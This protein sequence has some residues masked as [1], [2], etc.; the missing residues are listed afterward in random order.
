[1]SDKKDMLDMSYN[2]YMSSKEGMSD[3]R[4]R[5]WDKQDIVQIF[6]NTFYLL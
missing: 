2:N 1:M 5:Q 4:Y 6:M 3:K